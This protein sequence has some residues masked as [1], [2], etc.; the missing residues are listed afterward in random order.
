V[1]SCENLRR[2][3]DIIVHLVSFILEMNVD[4]SKIGLMNPRIS[5]HIGDEDVVGIKATLFPIGCL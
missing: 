4:F 3:K 1:V 5:I 2:S